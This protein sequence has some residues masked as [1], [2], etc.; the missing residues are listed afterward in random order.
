MRKIIK[1]LIFEEYARTANFTIEGHQFSVVTV[2][3]SFLT[4]NLIEPATIVNLAIGD[5]DPEMAETMAEVL[6]QAAEQCRC[7]DKDAGK[8]YKEVFVAVEHL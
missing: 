3:Q 2:Q 4:D 5:V 8:N 1:Q 6:R 7:W